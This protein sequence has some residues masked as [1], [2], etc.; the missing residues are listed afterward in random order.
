MGFN[1]AFKGLML[2]TYGDCCLTCKLLALSYG[3]GRRRSWQ[4]F[5]L[6]VAAKSGKFGPSFKFFLYVT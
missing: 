4:G 1:S 3:E 5:E 6:A 2:L